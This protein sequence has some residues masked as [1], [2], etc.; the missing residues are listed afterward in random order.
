MSEANEYT[1]W[2][3]INEYAIHIPIIQRDYA[4]GRAFERI[5]EIRNSFLGSIQEALED[6]KHLDLD[7]VYGS[8]KNDKIFVPLDGQQRLTTLFLLHWY[9]AVKENCIDEVRQILIKFTYETRTSSRE[10]CN[11]L[12]NDSSALKNVEFKSLEKISDHIENANWFFMSW[13]RDPTI[14]S[15]L[16]MLDAIHSK[17]KTTSNLF[18]RLTLTNY[19]P[20]SFQ[21]I[22]LDNLGLEDSL[23]IKMNA[24]GK[25]L[26]T[27]ENFKAKFQQ[28]LQK[29]ED[30]IELTNGFTKHFLA[31]I[32]GDW[33]DLF[34][35]YRDYTSNI[36]DN[37]IMN[38]IRAIIINNYALKGNIADLED[39]LNYLV[40]NKTHISFA[41]YMEYGCFD[42]D[43][44]YEI[45]ITLDC[46]SN[47]GSEIRAY[48][49]DS[50]VLDEKAL[51]EKIIS[52]LPENKP[53]YTDRI[54]LFAMTQYFVANKASID[55]ANFGEWIRVVRNLAVNTIDNNASEFAKSIQS[56]KELISNSKDILHFLTE[57]TNNI[58]R[59]LGDQV[60]EERVKAVLI[61]K[62]DKWRQTIIQAEEHGY[63]KGQIGFLL[64]FSGVLDAYNLDK[65]LK[66][67][68]ELGDG[69][70]EKFVRYFN[71]AKAIFGDKGLKIDNDLWRRALLCKGD[72]LLRTSRNLS[73][74]IDSHRDVSW[75]RLLRD[76]SKKRDYVKELLDDI[77]EKNL[78]ASLQK[79]I[80]N[81]NITDWRRY[82]IKIP[83]VM[84]GCGQ[85]RF[86]RKEDDNNILLLNSS[87]TSGYCKEY[88]TYALYCDLAKNNKG[89]Q[90]IEARGVDYDKYIS[91]YKNNVNIQITYELVGNGWSYVIDIGGSRICFDTQDSV[92]DH[93][94]QGKYVD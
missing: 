92:M 89:L 46:L 47:A 19:A 49:P 74:L 29:K 62:G 38:F 22:E 1:F 80:D 84:Q 85:R 9:L 82:F 76:D 70:H 44:I 48:L 8:M 54:M 78:E 36:F 30:D 93:L 69:Y 51:F 55:S 59:F 83:A 53:T 64:K 52:N 73:F 41:K 63:F 20:I 34:W 60:E 72:F 67:S 45:A 11:A 87:T 10:F 16:V 42:N 2:Q 40:D 23:Y 39:R 13:Q 14:K 56:V 65:E 61:L 25:A 79:I 37:Q 31:K 81:S 91:I 57:S 90:Y 86:I 50:V 17:F 7:F 94:R 12:V 33:T 18:D 35:N 28:F 26:T 24:R 32:D 77:D 68:P 5:E 43:V 4:Q 15:M 27:F 21:F 71:K 58:S 75:K 88:Y 66:S 6:N 3:L